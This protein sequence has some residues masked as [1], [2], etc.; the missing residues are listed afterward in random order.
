MPMW[1]VFAGLHVMRSAKIPLIRQ[2]G[3]QPNAKPRNLRPFLP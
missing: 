1:D 3:T 2:L